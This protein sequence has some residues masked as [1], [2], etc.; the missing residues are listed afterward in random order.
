MKLFA[1]LFCAAAMVAASLSVAMATEARV[2][3]AQNTLSYTFIEINR[4]GKTLWLAADVIALQPG[5]YIKFD[6]GYLMLNFHS[7]DLERTFS[8]LTFVENVKVILFK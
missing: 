5:D 2:V 4:D 3:S 1:R 7:N 6:E 8:N